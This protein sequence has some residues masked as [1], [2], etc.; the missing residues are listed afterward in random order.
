[1]TR[2]ALEVS[3]AAGRG[4]LGGVGGTIRGVV[5]ALLADDPGTEYLLCTRLSRARK[6][7]RWRPEAP[8]ARLRLIADPWNGLLLAGAKL[9]HAM[10]VFVPTTPR[11]PKLV[12]IH[13][14]NA[15]RNTEW[16]SEHWHERRGGKIADAVA[17]ADHVVTYSEFTAGEVC[18]EYGLPRE[19]VHPVHLGVDTARFQPAAPETVAKL[20]ERYGDYV[21]SIGLLSR[22]KNF[23]ALVAALERLPELRL[24]LV[25]R[26]SDGER[27]LEE[28][29]DRHGL[30]ARTTRLAGLPEDELVALLGAARACAVPSLYEGFGLTVLEAMA[31]GTPLVCSRAASLPEAAGDAALLVDARQPEE[32]A[33]ALLRVT[34][35][36]ALAAELRARGLA[37]AQAMS[38]TASARKLRA[39][40]RQ[41]SGA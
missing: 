8:N 29:L 6:G 35:D 10:N 26:G 12:T 11:V 37:R 5:G 2:L 24:V 28:S 40:Y 33:H 17:R 36:S 14:L 3:S 31:C 15:V 4:P 41:V 38:W 22:R 34:H 32:L 21:I 25:G 7:E 19:R 20:R 18:E 30:R 13:D 9:F 23:P 16:V 27:E 1:M 39:V